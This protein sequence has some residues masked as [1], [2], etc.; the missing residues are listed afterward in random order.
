LTKQYIIR[1]KETHEQLF[2]S[3]GKKGVWNT[4]GHAKAAFTVHHAYRG[5]FT[6]DEQDVFEIIEVVPVEAAR[7][8]QAEELLKRAYNFLDN[9]H[10]YDSDISNDIREY[11]GE[12][13]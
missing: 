5:G 13:E 7:L 1:N 3:Y 2:T 12:Q 4:A 11:F 6:F 9:V 8:Q 10:A